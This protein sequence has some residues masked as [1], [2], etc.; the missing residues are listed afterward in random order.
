MGIIFESKQAGKWIKRLAIPAGCV[1]LLSLLA[2]GGTRYAHVLQFSAVAAACAA[3]VYL[4]AR[5]NPSFLRQPFLVAVG[6]YSYAM[7]VF[8][9]FV[10]WL[11]WSGLSLQTVVPATV[12][13]AVFPFAAGAA[14]FVLAALSYR[15]YETPFLRL[16]VRFEPRDRAFPVL[17]A[18][19]AEQAAP[20]NAQQQVA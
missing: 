1:T 17:V 13:R 5:Y 18:L 9:I 14:T 3:V 15:C 7:Y 6:K 2:C 8:H 16:K 12:T 20:M 4:T 11:L 19:R 10:G